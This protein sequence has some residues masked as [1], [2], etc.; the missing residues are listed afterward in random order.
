M[1][2]RKFMGGLAVLAVTVVFAAAP[3]SAAHDDKPADPV[4]TSEQNQDHV[5][6][7]AMC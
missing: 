5:V 4:E 7:E 3:V 1:I 2:L 6:G